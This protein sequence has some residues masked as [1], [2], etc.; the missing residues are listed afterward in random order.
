MCSFSIFVLFLTAINVK[1][2]NTDEDVSLLVRRL[3]KENKQMK[4]ELIE[5]ENVESTLVSSVVLA[6]YTGFDCSFS[7]IHSFRV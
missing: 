5:K 6:E 2:Q 7:R 4:Q 1:A 3:L